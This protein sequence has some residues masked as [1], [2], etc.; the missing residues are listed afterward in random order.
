MDITNREKNQELENLYKKNEK[1]F[2]IEWESAFQQQPPCCLNLFGIVDEA[3]Y[4]DILFIGKETNG[5]GNEYYQKEDRFLPWL[6][7]LSDKEDRARGM[8]IWYNVGR[9]AMYIQNPQMDKDE[10]L[11][12]KGAALFGLK[13]IAFTNINKVRG[14]NQSGKEYEILKNS[15]IAKRTLCR[16]IHILDPKV[17]VLCG[18]KKEYISSMVG[19]NVRII[20]MPHPSARMKKRD[21][22][23]I[24]ERQLRGGE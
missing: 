20:E 1:E 10:L 6:D 13:Y 4:A 9:W 24:L 15:C 3:R 22:L 12:K 19:E 11:T 17:I 2:L 7:R 21:M 23:D 18:I 5:W 16:E 14:L 8:Q